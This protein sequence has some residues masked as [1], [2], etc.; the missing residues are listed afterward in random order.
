MPAE[1]EEKT[2]CIKENMTL[3]MEVADVRLTQL[4]NEKQFAQQKADLANI[5]ADTKQL[6]TTIN[7]KNIDQINENLNTL[8]NQLNQLNK[9]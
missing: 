9:S 5:L 4:I 3:I 2:E 7:D 1:D 6:L 8:E